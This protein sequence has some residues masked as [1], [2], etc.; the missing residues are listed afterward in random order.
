MYL[1]WFTTYD[2]RLLWQLHSVSFNKRNG[3]CIIYDER[4]Q[5]YI[6]S[7]KENIYRTVRLASTPLSA[8]SFITSRSSQIIAAYENGDVFLLNSESIDVINMTVMCPSLA[9][10]AIRLIRAHPSKPVVAMASDDM[11]VALWDLRW[12]LFWW[13]WIVWSG[14]VFVTST[15]GRMSRF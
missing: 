3:R 4:G 8:M 12:E 10:S 2:L 5:I 11:T 6:F 1:C 15:R 13:Q 14:P 9:K 7:V